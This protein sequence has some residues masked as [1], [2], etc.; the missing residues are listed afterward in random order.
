MM[1]LVKYLWRMYQ[2]LNVYDLDLRRCHSH[3][4]G[5][6]RSVAEW[7]IGMATVGE[8]RAETEKGREERGERMVL[9]TGMREQGIYGMVY[10]VC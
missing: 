10:E 2:V 8:F 5:A 1:A 3:F 9:A 6:R 4:E 7:E